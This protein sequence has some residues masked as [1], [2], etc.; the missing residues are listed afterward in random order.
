MVFVSFLI[1]YFCKTV[2]IKISDT[3]DADDCSTVETIYGDQLFTFAL[4]E[5]YNHTLYPDSYE[6]TGV[7]QCYC[8]E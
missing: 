3:Y 2:A 1:I 8:D 6:L 7:L 4:Y 5:Y